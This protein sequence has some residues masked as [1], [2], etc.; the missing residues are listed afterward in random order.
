[1]KLL[2]RLP[3][4]E[5][6]TSLRF[7]DRHVTI[8]ANQILVWVS[9]HLAGIPVPEDNIPKLP[10]LLDTGNN[11]DFSMQDR[12]LREWAGIDPDMLDV[13]GDIAIDGKVVTRRAA[14]V[15]LY[16]NVPG[17]QD[18]AS[19]RSPFR[20]EMS[21]GIAVYAQGADPPGPRLPLL[22][23]PAFLGNDLDFWLDPE[24]R[25]VTVQSRTWRRPLIRLLC[26]S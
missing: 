4:Q 20:L 25:H 10:A 24:R 1:M 7:G 19:D 17:G 6:R 12:H 3:I 14:T 2:D 5:H 22:G 23:L 15:W 18:A 8:H 13:R 26:R 9:V 16:P 21:K 11:F